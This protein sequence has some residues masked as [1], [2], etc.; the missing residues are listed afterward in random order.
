MPLDK[1]VELTGFE[2]V[3]SS[4]PWKRATNCAIAP[5]RLPRLPVELVMCK[6]RSEP[7]GWPVTVPSS[8]GLSVGADRVPDM[9]NLSWTAKFVIAFVGAVVFFMI[10]YQAGQNSATQG[11]N[12]SDNPSTTHPATSSS[13][14]SDSDQI[15]RQLFES[16]ASGVQ[17]SGSG[18]V[19]NRL[20]DDDNDGRHQRFILKL[21]S[22]QTLLIA[23]NI[24]I[25][26][27]LTGLS[28]GDRV[29]FYGEYVYSAQGGIIHWTHHDPSG[30]HTDGW[31]EWQGQ[32]YS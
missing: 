14:A 19:L 29:D 11:T 32:R 20:P 16:Q 7:S 23:H 31:L 6:T 28:E 24:D 12:P 13:T 26:P 2:P 18:T 15:L 25:A 9:K 22:G 5:V 1:L 27:Y 4:M 21:A 8:R 10:G 17:V 30:G 3:A